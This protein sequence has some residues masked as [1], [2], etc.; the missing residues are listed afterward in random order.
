VYPIETV[1]TGLPYL[2]IPLKSNIS[3]SKIMRNDFE[4]FLS[5]FKAKFVY[6]FDTKTLECRTWD[7]IAHTEDVA[8]GSA[9][10]P[11][12]AYLVKHKI[13]THNEVINLHQGRFVNRPSVITGWVSQNENVESVFITGKVSFFA[14]GEV[15]V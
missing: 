5:A 6:V 3:N 14:C 1:S 7:N 9:A 12:C 10:G 11:L 15:F 13:K 8:T 4:D 2:L